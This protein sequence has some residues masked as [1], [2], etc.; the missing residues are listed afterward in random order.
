MLRCIESRDLCKKGCGDTL[1]V[2]AAAVDCG[3][4]GHEGVVGALAVSNFLEHFTHGG[5]TKVG[6]KRFAMAFSEAPAA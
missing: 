2:M 5:G 3:W 6:V 1:P 4:G